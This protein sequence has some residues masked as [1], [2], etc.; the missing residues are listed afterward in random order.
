[1]TDTNY[2]EKNRVAWN[3][4]TDHHV[5]AAFYDVAGFINGKNS[6]NDIELKLLGDVKGK[7]VLH[8]Q[9]HFGQDSISLA[10]LGAMVTGADLSDHAIGKANEL[11]AKTGQAL[12]FICCDLYDLPQHLEQQFDIVF[13]SY[14]TIGWLPDLDKWAK[15]IARYLKPGGKFVFAEFHPVVWMFDNDFEKVAYTYAMSDPIIETEQGTYADRDAPITTEM[16]TWNH[17]VA[18]VLTA[19][20]N[21]GMELTAFE[22]YDYSPYNCFNKTVEFEP[23]K[24]RI[25]HFDNK[26]PMLYALSAIKK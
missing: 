22:E 17:S 19:L 4:R 11:A 20:L 16:I 6:L 12:T 15:I 21:N 13:T 8:L 25:A 3:S 14:G 2:I 7:S 9:C 1:M 24:F 26:I 10:R 5:D 18:E 23:G